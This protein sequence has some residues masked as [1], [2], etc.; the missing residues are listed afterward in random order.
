MVMRKPLAFRWCRGSTRTRRCSQ[1]AS[2]TLSASACRWLTSH[3]FG[4]PR[5]QTEA[6]T[7]GESAADGQARLRLK[8]HFDITQLGPNAQVVARAMQMFGIVVAD[9]AFGA[10]PKWVMNG[11]YDTRWN[12][13]DMNTLY[14]IVPT[15]MEWVLPPH[16]LEPYY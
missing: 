3:S 2:H 13:T 4:Q 10:G 15:D 5:T 6:R 9:S 16:L 14:K 8:G 1:G 7:I 12:D 11:A